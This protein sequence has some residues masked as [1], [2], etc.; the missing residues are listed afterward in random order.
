MTYDNWKTTDPADATADP[1][2]QAIDGHCPQ[3]DDRVEEWWNYCAMC[4]HHI[5]A[6]LAGKT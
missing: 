2:W 4:G 3:C 6:G 5:A 1:D